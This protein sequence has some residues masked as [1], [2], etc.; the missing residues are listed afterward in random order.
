MGRQQSS[1]TKR[2]GQSQLDMYLEEAT[3]GLDYIEG[4]TWYVDGN[5][6]ENEDE[7]EGPTCSKSASNILDLDD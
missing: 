5:D 7:K 1:T 3:L 4:S 6:D 2:N